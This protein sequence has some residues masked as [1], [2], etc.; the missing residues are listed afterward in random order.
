MH[1]PLMP[2]PSRLLPPPP[3]THIYNPM[4]CVASTHPIGY[5]QGL[6]YVLKELAPKEGEERIAERRATEEAVAAAKE[7][8]AKEKK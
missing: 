2:G 4:H 8:A 1:S 7:A 5:I 3:A 6:E